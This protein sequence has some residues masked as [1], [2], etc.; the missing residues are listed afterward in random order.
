VSEPGESPSPVSATPRPCSSS[1]SDA[2]QRV[3]PRAPS[4]PIAGDLATNSE[5][6]H[7]WAIRVYAA[8]DRRDALVAQYHKL[9]RTA[10]KRLESSAEVAPS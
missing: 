4:V 1:R 10:P 2:R 7:G 6:F 8:H 3:I 9:Q 5:A